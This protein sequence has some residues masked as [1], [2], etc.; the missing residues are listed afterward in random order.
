VEY[1]RKSADTFPSNQEAFKEHVKQF[2]SESS[3]PVLYEFFDFLFLTLDKRLYNVDEFISHIN[4]AL[5]NNRS[6]HRVI[7]NSFVLSEIH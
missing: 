6:R 5:I 1:F 2:T 7:G 3:G 4:T